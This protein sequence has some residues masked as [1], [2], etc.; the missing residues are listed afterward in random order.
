MKKLLSAVVILFTG[1]SLVQAQN[2]PPDRPGIG[3]SSFI[4]PQN[5][6]GVEA[7]LQYTTTE[8]S[9]QIDIGQVLVRYGIRE[10]L[11]FRA[12]FNSYSSTSFDG[13]GQSESGFQD[14]AAGLKFNFISGNGNP[15]VS[16]LLEFSLPVGSA[17]YTSNE[18]VP[19]IAVLV[20]HT[21]SETWAVSSNLGYNFA[22]G[23]L[24]DNWLFTLTPGFSIPTNEQISGYFGYAG[25]YFGNGFDQHW[26][27]GGLTYALESGVQLDVNMGYETEAEVFFIGAGFAKGFSN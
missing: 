26:L 16:G 21:L 24:E 13:A 22:A 23:N 7:G 12:L 2:F 18:V 25:R 9:D 11:E 5:M 15:N 6:L 10:K 27:E 19:T 20:D 17:V 8:F 4:T 3:N 14:M 1:F